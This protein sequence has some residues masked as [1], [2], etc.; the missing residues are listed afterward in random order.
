MGYDFVVNFATYTRVYT[1]V[2]QKVALRKSKS[3]AKLVAEVAQKFY[4]SCAKVAHNLAHFLDVKYYFGSLQILATNN[5]P[6][7][8]ATMLKKPTL[9]LNC[10]LLWT[11][12]DINVIRKFF[13]CVQL[14][15]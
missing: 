9:G 10:S 14:V 15:S 5:R 12:Y 4:Q 8:R 2:P 7:S 3:C 1:V 13:T 11:G 6:V